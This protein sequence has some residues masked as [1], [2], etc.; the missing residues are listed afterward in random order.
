MTTAQR[1]PLTP[2]APPE[3]IPGFYTRDEVSALF[4]TVRRHAPWRLVLAHHFTS[5]EEYLAI[6]GGRDRNSGATL[7]DFTAPVFRGYLAKEGIVLFDELHDI[8]LSRKLLDPVLRL[9]GARY[10]FAS[11]MLFNICGPAHSFDAGHFDG[12]NW[13]GISSVGCPVWLMGVMAKSGLFDP[14]LV[15]TGQV[16]TYFYDSDIDGGFTYW[17]DGPEMAPRRLAPPFRNTAVLSDNSRMYHRREASGPRDRRDLPALEMTSLLHADGDAWSIR[18]GET[19]IAR[20]AGKDSRTLFHYTAL[21]FDDAS[22]V[23]RYLDHTD[24]LTYEKVFDLLIADLK[25]RG[26]KF[27]E[28]SDPMT[29]RAFI[30]LLTETYAMAPRQYPAEAPLDVHAA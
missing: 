28:P 20:F 1:H 26:S 11:H 27:T 30:S 3:V 15:K 8:Y 5:T 25:G 24:D 22:D 16:I 2:V 17:P 21:V 7:A 13:R 18:N 4:G 10:G 6:S 9:H 29:N 14:W 12:G 23:N 19:E